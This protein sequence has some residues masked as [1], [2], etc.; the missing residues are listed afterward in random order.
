[1]AV[2]PISPKEIIVDLDKIIPEAVIQAVNNLLKEKYRGGTVTLQ[3]KEITAAIRKI[4]KKLTNEI[5]FDKHYMDFEPIFNKAGW[6][7]TYDKPGW[8]EDYEP[9]YDFKP[10]K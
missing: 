1:M 10:I 6:K 2:K 7:V 8:D 9:H 5:L 4:D 3:Q